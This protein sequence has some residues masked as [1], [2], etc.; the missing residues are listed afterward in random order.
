V[1]L[2]CADGRHGGI[3]G[4]DHLTGGQGPALRPPA[5]LA[6][7]P[8]MRLARPRELSIETPLRLVRQPRRA[9]QACVGGLRQRQDRRAQLQHMRRRLAYQCHKDLPHA[10]ALATKA[11]HPPLEAGLAS[12]G[13]LVEDRPLGGARHGDGREDLE[14]CF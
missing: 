11:A 8:V 12:H 14:D 13:P 7:D 1:A 3:V 5:G 10:P 2:P 9:V 4:M 6:C